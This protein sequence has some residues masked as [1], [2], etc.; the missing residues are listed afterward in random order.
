MI[1]S[2]VNFQSCYDTLIK[3]SPELKDIPNAREFFRGYH[4][5]FETADTKNDIDWFKNHYEKFGG[6]MEYHCKKVYPVFDLK[7]YKKWQQ[8]KAMEG[9]NY[10]YLEDSDED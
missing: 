7:N 5:D 1:I 4:L 6:C 3:R 2:T 8:A 9:Q 10:A